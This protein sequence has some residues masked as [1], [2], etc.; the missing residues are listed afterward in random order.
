MAI[1]LAFMV[2]RRMWVMLPVIPARVHG[3]LDYAM[4]LLLIVSP[5]LFGFAPDNPGAET[6]VPVALGVGAILYSLITDY[7]LGTARILPMQ[8][9]LI[10]DAMSGILLAASPWLFGFSE[11][12]WLPHL[13]LGIAELGV[14]AMTS[15]VPGNRQDVPH[16][17]TAHGHTPV[18]R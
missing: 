17:D 4:G 16:M 13:V 18:T 9:H 10:L 12:L 7:E 5:W 14:A 11:Y 3:F 1:S 6:W 2:I 15:A 8:V